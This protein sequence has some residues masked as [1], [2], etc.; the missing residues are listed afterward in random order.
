MVFPG[1][2]PSGGIAGS[3]RSS[4][5]SFFFSVFSFLK[6]LHAVFHLLLLLL[7]CWPCFRAMVPLKKAGWVSSRLPNFGDSIYASVLIAVSE[8]THVSRQRLSGR[9]NSYPPQVQITNTLLFSIQV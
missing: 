8:T 7:I 6:H 3:Y 9:V 2:M 5:F 4:V 1:F